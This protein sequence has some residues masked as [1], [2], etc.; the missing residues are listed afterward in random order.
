[1]DAL[2]DEASQTIDK[3]QREALTTECAALLNE[4]CS[5]APLY[6]TLSLRA[7]NADLQGVT[8]NA[9]GDL[10]IEDISWK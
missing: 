6:Q 1:M 7:F 4:L 10:R 8:V 2:I 9:N 5:Q 3:E